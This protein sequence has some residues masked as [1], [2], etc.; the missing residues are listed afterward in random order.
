MKALV[1]KEDRAGTL[2][3]NIISPVLVYAAE[4]SGEIADNILAIDQAMK[5]GFGWEQGPFETWDA[6]GVEKAVAKMELDGQSIPQWIKEMLAK[7]YTSF[8]QNQDGKVSYYQNGEY[9]E[10]PINPKVINLKQ[11]KNKLI[12]LLKK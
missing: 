5:W 6:I 4:L 11:L 3:W 7:G 2:L 10:I 1:Y 9:R 12:K 8:Y